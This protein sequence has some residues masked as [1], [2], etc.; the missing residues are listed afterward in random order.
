ME[1]NEV[2]VQNEQHRRIAKRILRIIIKSMPSVA[3]S[4]KIKNKNVM[5]NNEVKMPLLGEYEGSIIPSYIII[6]GDKERTLYFCIMKEALYEPIKEIL[7][8]E[9]DMRDALTLHTIKIQFACPGLGYGLYFKKKWKGLLKGK[10]IHLYQ[11]T[12]HDK[13]EEK[14]E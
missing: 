6:K 14:E 1:K 3:P 5:V 12:L 7:T 13:K 10:K 4:L 11:F 2:D 8:K 9:L